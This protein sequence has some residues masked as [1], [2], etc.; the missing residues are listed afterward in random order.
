MQCP[1]L[2][3]PFGTLYVALFGTLYLGHLVSDGPRASRSYTLYSSALRVTHRAFR[4]YDPAGWA[5]P[6]DPAPADF[7]EAFWTGAS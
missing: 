4:V 6:F 1:P 7:P 3:L 5:E 2:I